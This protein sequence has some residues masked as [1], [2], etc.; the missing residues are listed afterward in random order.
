[1]G[2]QK[3][4]DKFNRLKD[5]IVNNH[6][7][8]IRKVPLSES[9]KL[10]FKRASRAFKL[11]F[12]EKEIIFYAFMQWLSVAFGYI[13]CIQILDWIPDDVWKDIIDEYNRSGV[14]SRRF[15][16]IDIVLN[17]WIFFC[18]GLVAY[19][20]SIAT[21]CMGSVHFF[22]REKSESTIKNSFEAVFPNVWSLWIFTW[23]DG[24]ITVKQI[25][26]RLQRR[27]GSYSPLL[28]E[29]IYYTWKV[30][31]MGILPALIAGRNILNAG[32][33]SIDLIKYKYDEILLLR[34]GYSIVC[35]VIGIL[36]Y[37]GSL[38]YLF[39]FG[40]PKRNLIYK[41]IYESYLWLAFPI[42]ASVLLIKLFIRPIYIISLC[43]IY[44]DYLDET[45][46]EVMKPKPLAKGTSP[47]IVFVIFC[48]IFAIVIRYRYELGI[49][50]LLSNKY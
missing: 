6:L 12:T 15:S 31:T 25:Y 39:I 48:I 7:I 35:W 9:I 3:T 20:L 19:P 27:R 24:W 45:S 47:A 44:H 32:K 2:I 14:E 16:V 21:A 28:S 23:I 5:E 18:I 22:N 33:D 30:A 26:N 50:D 38:F 46:Q 40:V 11:I 42:L 4:W 41:E 34:A 1:M 49:T 10:F 8:D 43:D 29:T 36:T 17:I 13:L 37:V